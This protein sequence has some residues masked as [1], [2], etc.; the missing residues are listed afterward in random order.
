M[1][2][3]RPRPTQ[4]KRHRHTAASRRR[5][6]PHTA[7]S[8]RRRLSRAFE[9]GRAT[10]GAVHGGTSKYHHAWPHRLV[11]RLR[12]NIDGRTWPS[13]RCARHAK[14]QGIAGD[15]VG[16]CGFHVHTRR[17]PCWLVGSPRSPNSELTTRRRFGRLERSSKS[18]SWSSGLEPTPR[19][20]SSTGLPAAWRPAVPD[21][22]R[23]WTRRSRKHTPQRHEV[24]LRP[25]NAHTRTLAG[26]DAGDGVIACTTDN[27]VVRLDPATWAVTA[28]VSTPSAPDGCAWSPSRVRP[29]SSSTRPTPP[30]CRSGSS[31]PRRSSTTRPTSRS[32]TADAT[33]VSS[34]S[35]DA[36]H[37]LAPG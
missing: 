35:A 18:T 24:A 29:S 28:R 14:G 5:G 15:A 4:P 8:R 34:F 13:G 32:V 16:A 2:A 36:V 21:S 37:R 11:G 10:V 31:E 23:E 17:L 12:S 33:W 25:E 19:S 7:A 26:R 1:P 27:V 20:Q 30:W 3:P 22:Q 9:L 6:L